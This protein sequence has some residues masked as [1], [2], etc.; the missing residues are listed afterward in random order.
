MPLAPRRDIRAPQMRLRSPWEREPL[1]VF[2]ANV[3]AGE[4]WKRGGDA[5]VALG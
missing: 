5:C 3:G 4:E 1:W 2:V